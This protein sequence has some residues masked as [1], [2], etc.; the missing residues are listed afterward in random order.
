[1]S[2]VGEWLAAHGDLPRLDR[3]VLISRATGL[4]RAQVLGRPERMLAPAAADHLHDWAT[5]R[6][7]GEPLAYIT[8]DKEF[9]GLEFAVAPGVLVPR[10]DTEC[11]VD[12]ALGTAGAEPTLTAPGACWLELGTGSGAVAGALAVAAHRRGWPVSLIAT[13]ISADALTIAAGNARRHG[14]RITWHH[15]NWF[16]G[17]DGPFPLI[18]SNPPYVADDDPHLAD[19]IHEPRLALTAGP[20]GLDA[21][22]RIVADVPGYLAIGGWVVLEHGAAQGETVRALLTATGLERVETH[23]DLA[24]L[25]RVTRARRPEG[26]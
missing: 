10:P 19:L 25:D 15:G 1:V 20:D 7:A 8:G 4:S 9:W 14:A 23:Q 5:R 6:R 21:I 3:E 22:R 17:V 12:V 24:G 16:A 13:D 18:V 2:T 26:A 11:L